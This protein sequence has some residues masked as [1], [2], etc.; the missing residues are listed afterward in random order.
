M[1]I[2]DPSHGRGPQL[3]ELLL[4]TGDY[5]AGGSWS[6]PF[7]ALDE[8][9]RRRPLIFGEVSDEPGRYCSLLKEMFSGRQEDPEEWAV[10]WKEI[11]ADG[12]WIDM[13]GDD[14]SLVERIAVR[15]RLP[16]AVKGSAQ[17]LSKLTMVHGT[18][19]IFICRD[20]TY[21]G[22][23]GDHVLSVQGCCAEALEMGSAKARSAGR[24]RI[25]LDLGGFDVSEDLGRSVRKAEKVRERALDENAALMHP[26]MA[27]TSCCW[28]KDFKDA[29]EAS[30]WE[31]EAALAAMLSGADIVLM[32][33]PG[34]A[35]MA[36]V[37]GEELADL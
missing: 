28:K 22:P 37:Y 13:H 9:R 3:E 18:V 32:R 30:M 25:V 7:L 26:T 14:A 17:L 4:G 36:R 27:D 23:M 1:E 10:M 8:A 24:R 21:S 11:G 34:A 6:V 20:G 5:V 31:A 2:P 35:D 29:R 16:V 15:T 12:V 19:M 33:G